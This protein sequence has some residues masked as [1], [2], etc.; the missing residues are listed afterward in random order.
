[1]LGPMTRISVTIGIVE[2]CWVTQDNYNQC[3]YW[4]TQNKNQG[5]RALLETTYQLPLTYRIT[6]KLKIKKNFTA[7][8]QKGDTRRIRCAQ[9]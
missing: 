3:D 8:T 1:M 7:P 2:Q 5:R 4:R 9:K 6:I